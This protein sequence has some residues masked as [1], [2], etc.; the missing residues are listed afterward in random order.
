MDRTNPQYLAISEYYDHA[1]EGHVYIRETLD[2]FFH[3]LGDRVQAL[4]HRARIL[5]LGSHAGVVSASLLERWPGSS[6]IVN[7]DDE[8]MVAI[9]RARLDS[10]H[11]VYNTGPLATVTQPVDFVTSIARHHHLPHGYLSDVRRVMTPATVYVLADE[12]CPE[13]CMGEHRARVEQAELISVVG[14]FVLTT[15][16]EVRAFEATG[17]IPDAAVA[18][19]QLRRRALWQWYRFVVDE[20]VARGYFD[21]AVGEL[22][23]TH[24]DLITGS[25]AEHKFSPLVVERQFALAGFQQL[26]KRL[27]GPIDDASRQSMFVYEFALT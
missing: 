26:S 25:D 3:V 27:I 11:V 5:E 19:E 17:T 20:A 24:D 4:E 21:I 9:S 18:L 12:F 6:L 23:S 10:P 8:T 1:I 15:F 13:Y 2:L 14:G 7:D 22:Q 16:D